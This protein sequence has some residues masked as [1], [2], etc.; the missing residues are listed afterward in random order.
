M[1]KRK[2]DI[3]LVSSRLKD[4][5]KEMGLTQLQVAEKTEMGLNSIK[6]YESGKRIPDQYNLDKLAVFFDVSPKFIL[7]ETTFRD[8]LEEHEF[9]CPE[10]SILREEESVFFEFMY[11]LGIDIN[12]VFE[13]CNDVHLTDYRDSIEAAVMTAHQN[14]IET[15]RKNEN[16]KT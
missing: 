2:Y 10:Q 6:Q 13:L 14:W 8:E 4:L 16:G 5:R 15:E 12:A 7:G 1:T 3:S 11:N 9:Y